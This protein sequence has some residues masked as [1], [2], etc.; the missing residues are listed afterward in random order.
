MR[1]GAGHLDACVARFV[2]DANDPCEATTGDASVPSPHPPNP[3]PYI[4]LQIIERIAI[5]YPDKIW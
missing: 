3:R 5:F 2:Q 1:M 4:L